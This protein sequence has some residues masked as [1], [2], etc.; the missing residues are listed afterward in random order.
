MDAASYDASLILDTI[1]NSTE[2]E[3]AKACSTS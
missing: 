1:E 2:R 3:E